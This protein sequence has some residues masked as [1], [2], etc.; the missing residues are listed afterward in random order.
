MKY[1]RLHS[2]S[3]LRHYALGIAYGKL[4]NIFLIGVYCCSHSTPKEA[5]VLKV[6]RAFRAQSHFEESSD[7]YIIIT[8]YIIY[9][10]ITYCII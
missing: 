9:C 6:F 10:Y 3:T 7:I 1:R 8:L 2:P 5:Q 4:P